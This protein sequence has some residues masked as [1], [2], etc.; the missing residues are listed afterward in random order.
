MFVRLR[1]ADAPDR[2][3]QE[4]QDLGR[5]PIATIE[6]TEPAALGAEFVRWEI[7]TAV[8]GSL[9][10]INPFDEPNVQQAKDA[11]RAL[12]D[13]YTIDHHLPT[14]AHQTTSTGVTLTVTSAARQAL[15]DKDPESILRTLAAG[16]YFAALPYLAPTTPSSSV[17]HHSRTPAPA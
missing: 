16:D 3:D 11:T 5:E 1:R 2:R 4:V 14:A 8:A 15:H 10:G 7:A 13:R 9:I 17:F 6:F 12:L